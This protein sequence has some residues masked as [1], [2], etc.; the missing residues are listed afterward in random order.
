MVLPVH[1]DCIGLLSF[2][3]ALY[4]Q[5]GGGVTRKVSCLRILR[6]PLT[7]WSICPS[8]MLPRYS[9]PVSSGTLSTPLILLCSLDN[10][11]TYIFLHIGGQLQLLIKRTPVPVLLSTHIASGTPGRCACVCVF[12]LVCQ[13]VLSSTWGMVQLLPFH[14]FF[15]LLLL[16][17]CLPLNRYHPSRP[18]SENL[19]KFF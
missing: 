12:V 13:V 1:P 18:T 2:S 17:F 11:F 14:S 4:L 10:L 6:S 5:E 9:L 16:L 19:L 3:H 15:N 8:L 7:S